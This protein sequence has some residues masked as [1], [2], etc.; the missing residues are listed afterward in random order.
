M[1]R[2]PN[3]FETVDVLRAALVET[4]FLLLRASYFLAGTITPSSP[5]RPSS[6][7]SLPLSSVSPSTRG[8]D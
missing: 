6:S 1:Q 7:P 2:E 8:G 3:V 4:D 5:T